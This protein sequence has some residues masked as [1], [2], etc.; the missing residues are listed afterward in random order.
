MVDG[1]KL[2]VGLHFP[3][4]TPD[5]SQLLQ[6]A[7]EDGYDYV[8]TALPSTER[9]KVRS[10][11]T[12]LTG[13]WWRTS[14][15]GIVQEDNTAKSFFEDVEKQIEWAIHMGIPA[16]IVP[17]PPPGGIPDYARVILSLALEAQASNLQIWV[18]TRLTTS[19]LGDYETM[20][21]LCDG[22]S[23]IGMILE[24]EPMSTMTSAAATVGTQMILMHKAIGMQLKA[25]T[26]PAKTFLTNKKGYPALAKSHQVLFTEIL[27]RI[28]RTLRVLVEGPSVHDEVPMSGQTKCMSYLQYIRHIRTR[29]ETT[30]VLDT[31][32]ASLETP[33]LDSLQRPLQP[34]KDHLE[35][36]MYETFEK[37]P[38]KYAKYQEAVYMALESL[39]LAQ[40]SPKTIT[41]AVAGA[42]R[43][44]LVMR[45]IQAFRQLQSLSQKLTLKVFALEK[46]PSAVVYL[47][48]MA[49][50]NGLWKGVVTVVNTDVRNLTK[51]H[52]DGNKID[53]IVSELLGSFGDNELSP[54]C[55]DPLM[56]SECCSSSTISIPMQYSAFVA[57]VSSC[58]L[59]VEATQQAQVPHEGAQ[60]LGIQ[61]AMETSYVV[62][63][64]AAS[65]T[66][67]EQLCWTFDHPS[68]TQ[69]K[70]RTATLEF[71]PDPTF[72]TQ[73]GCGYG[74]ADPAISRIVSE[75]QTSSTG[76]ITIH[77]LLGSFTAI[78]FA[79]G[80]SR[81]EISIAPH[82]F[83]EGMFSWFP[84][85]FPFFEP[86]RVP[87]GSNV[88]VNMW[89]K[90]KDTRV[91]FEW[92][93]TVHREG[94]IL[95]TTPIHNPNGRSS[96]VSM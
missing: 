67:V 41:I 86:I 25:V 60:P 7:R 10:D 82:E 59:H 45:S 39:N 43:G 21:R 6:S 36:S 85:Y 80:E 88:S 91:W 4:T 65:Q 16:V 46:N 50:N 73:L 53:I 38:V 90:T 17:P 75:A 51:D 5:A 95:A 72:A 87:A 20:H 83:S 93:A 30:A 57:P 61:R 92:C 56:G 32:E 27:K 47:Q 66:H 70:E 18:K 78:L 9:A 54:E 71:S 3:Q 29:S 35:F 48:S 84:I 12:A 94:E 2:V 31:E 52:L 8:T 74:P 96:H 33:Y 64:H 81:C 28:G 42:G 37:D 1:G 26:F 62:R 15:V 76:G 34:L 14:V 49:Q 44:P 22:L 68:K 55:L 19:S 24:I 23:N 79:K 40:D 63:T 69:N 13:R 89:R 58:R 11:V 77:G